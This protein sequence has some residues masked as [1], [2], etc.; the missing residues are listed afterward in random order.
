MV[1]LAACTGGGHD[2]AADARAVQDTVRKSLDAENRADVGAFLA[3]WT[4]DGLRSYDAGSR[5]DLESGKAHLGVDKTEVAD[6]ASTTVKGGTAEVVVDTRVELGLYRLRFDLV[7]KPKGW[8]LNGFGFLGPTPPPSTAKVVDVTTVEYGYNVD[9][10]G[11]AT[12]DFAVHLINNGKEQHEIAIVELPPAASPA[13]AV[14]AL[15][16]V[17]GRDF[18]GIPAGYTPLGHLAY[19]PPGD[20][21]VFS[22]AGKLPPGHY[23]MVCMLPV[24]GVDDVGNAKVANADSHVARG[25]LADF[26]VG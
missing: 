22:L 17:K 14:L 4:D 3:L 13:E 24:G 5:S 23:A 1:L 12:G 18:S 15:L 26:T 25:M 16:P 2:S 11:L 7:R 10:A 6:V 9:K 21:G 19:A 8:L 20:G